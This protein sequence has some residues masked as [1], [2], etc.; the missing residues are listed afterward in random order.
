M[1]L[2]AANI[3]DHAGAL[4]LLS[5]LLRQIASVML[6][7]A[8]G[9]NAGKLVDARLVLLPDLYGHA[10]SLV[11]SD[12][13]QQR[14]KVSLERLNDFRGFVITI[15]LRKGQVF[16][17]GAACSWLSTCWHG[18]VI[19]E[20]MD[21]LGRQFSCGNQIIVYAATPNADLSQGQL[22]RLIAPLKFCNLQVQDGIY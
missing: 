22:H 20:E 12:L 5:S 19:V 6:I 17:R 9:S 10:C 2:H 14:R 8:D 18:L 4:A 15:A 3:Q 16:G 1:Q 13:R 21:L 7:R 11:I